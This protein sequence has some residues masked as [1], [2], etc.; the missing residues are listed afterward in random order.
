[1]K[2]SPVAPAS[3]SRR[4]Q[5]RAAVLGV[6]LLL[7][8]GTGR[9]SAPA[10]TPAGGEHPKPEL[11]FRQGRIMPT[12]LALDSGGRYLIDSDDWGGPKY[13]SWLLARNFAH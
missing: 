3:L 4:P 1:M 11:V 12:M 8:L 5:F 10:Q 13:G 7:V 2:S 6:T 9:H